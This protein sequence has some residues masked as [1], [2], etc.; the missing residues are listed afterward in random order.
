MPG[1]GQLL[2]L[3]NMEL[4]GSAKKTGRI[5]GLLYLVVIMTGIFSL[6][7]VPKKLFVWDDPAV[8][9][10]NIV[11]SELLFRL[12][13]VSSVLCYTAF[14]FLPLALYKLLKPVSNTAAISMAILAITSVPISLINL[15]NKF[16][17]LNLISRDKY[18]NIYSAEQ[19]N[20]QVLFYLNQYDNG[21]LI[22]MVFWGLWLF[23][24]GYLVYRSGFLPKFLGVL[25]MLGC[26]GYLINFTGNVLLNNYAQ[27]GIAKYVSM[28]ATLGEIGI[29]IWL[30]IGR[31]PKPR[32][33]LA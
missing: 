24:F 28:P 3:N 23:P 19:L 8:T 6:A 17:V 14:I 11:S 4:I 18:L 25:L 2:I 29:C 33:P 31:V 12:S 22:A 32:E 27:I 16:S 7:Y 26:F 1:N 15:Q 21:I 9:F 5:A 30:L 20:S 13:I 10:N